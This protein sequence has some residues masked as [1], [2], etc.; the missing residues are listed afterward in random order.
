MSS[1]T[2]F[3][4]EQ[5]SD[6]EEEYERL[7]NLAKQEGAMRASCFERVHR[8]SKSKTFRFL[9]ADSTFIHELI[10]IPT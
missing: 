4:H 9:P 8:P 7:R 10:E 5:S 2:A 3:N 6:A 1:H